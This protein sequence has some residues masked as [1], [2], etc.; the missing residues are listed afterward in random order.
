MKK[1]LKTLELN[2]VNLIEKRDLIHNVE[3]GSQ[4]AF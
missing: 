4:G 3:R 1:V 2:S